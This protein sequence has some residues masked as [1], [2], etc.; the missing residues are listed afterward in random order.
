[1]TKPIF[2]FIGLALVYIWSLTLEVDLGGMATI[3][4]V[5]I[6]LLGLYGILLAI[7]YRH[8]LG[9]PNYDKEP[10]RRRRRRPSDTPQ[11]NLPKKITEKDKLKILEES[12]S[13]GQRIRS[14]MTETYRRTGR[15]S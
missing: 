8:E 10:K 1:M 13:R 6:L 4:R 7:T 12:A 2:I 9:E 14:K 5:G 3:L 11:S 15:P